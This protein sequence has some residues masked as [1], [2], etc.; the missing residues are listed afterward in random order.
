MLCTFYTRHECNAFRTSL[1][2]HCN[3][4]G[5]VCV[6]VCV[7]LKCLCI[8]RGS[9][10]ANSARVAFIALAHTQQRIWIQ[11]AYGCTLH[12][13]LRDTGVYISTIII[14]GVGPQLFQSCRTI[15]ENRRSLFAPFYVQLDATAAC[16][17]VAA[18]NT[19]LCEYCRII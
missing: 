11:S 16:Q 12:T 1:G 19:L 14:F 6:C 10:E 7:R 9:L 17:P 4:W 15:R 5:F 13:E 18:W 3:R 2:C 8:Y